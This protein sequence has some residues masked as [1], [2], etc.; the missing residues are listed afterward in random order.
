[1]ST[2]AIPQ[3]LKKCCFVTAY[4]HI[5]FLNVFLRNKNSANMRPQGWDPAGCNQLEFNVLIYCQTV[6]IQVYSPKA[7]RSVHCIYDFLYVST[8]ANTPPPQPPAPPPPRDPPRGTP[9]TITQADTARID[10]TTGGGGEG[11][12]MTRC[13]ELQE[14]EKVGWEDGLNYG[15]GGGRMRRC[16]ELRR[17]RR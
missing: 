12:R 13:T 16:T 17:K 11:G 14:G 7:I 4:Q 3:L 6:K 5:L 8:S 10:W 1:M 2:I 9:R 15:G